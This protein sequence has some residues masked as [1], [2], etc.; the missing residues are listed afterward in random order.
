MDLSDE[1]QMQKRNVLLA[2]LQFFEDL[3][4]QALAKV[5]AENP[6]YAD[7]TLRST[8]LALVSKGVKLVALIED[9]KAK[10]GSFRGFREQLNEGREQ[11]NAKAQESVIVDE[12][13]LRAS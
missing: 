11:A 4:H 6:K 3:D 7:A 10:M 2:T 8:T 12:V 9:K 1:V 13:V 5:T